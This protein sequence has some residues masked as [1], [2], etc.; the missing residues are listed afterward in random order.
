MEELQKFLKTR[1]RILFGREF[2]EEELKR[3][4]R[5]LALA[6]IG[7][8]PEDNFFIN[9]E[10]ID[11]AVEI[12][13]ERV[14]KILEQGEGKRKTVSFNVLAIRNGQEIQLPAEYWQRRLYVLG[15]HEVVYGQKKTWWQKN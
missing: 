14:E 13:A 8:R 2:S 12:L 7:D 10:N 15:W 5:F 3:E 1:L 6:S 9:Q 4:I 11:E